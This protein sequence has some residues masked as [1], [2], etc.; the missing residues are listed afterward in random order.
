MT[1]TDQITDTSWH[2]YLLVGNDGKRTYIGASNDPERR[3][4]CHNGEIVG[5]ARATQACRPWKH[6]CIIS[7]LSKRYALQLEW[8]LKKWKSPKTGKLK[9]CPGLKNRIKNV[10]TVLGLEQWTSNSVGSGELP[11]WVK[12]FDGYGKIGEEMPEHIKCDFEFE[13]NKP[14]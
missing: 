11:L 13:C 2:V 6:V 14:I 4:R 7:G 12:W 3:L 9:T 1:D 5:G 10:Y 8:R